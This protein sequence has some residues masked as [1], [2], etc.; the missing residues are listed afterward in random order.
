MVNRIRALAACS[1]PR[2]PSDR[3]HRGPDPAPPAERSIGLLLPDHRRKRLHEYLDVE[4]QAPIVD[5][6]DVE[7]NALLHHVDRGRLSSQPMDLGPT[8]NA[9]LDVMA[10]GIFPDQL[11]VFVVVDRG[12]R[13]WTDQ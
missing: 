12:V 4:P 3:P 2:D 8:G 7:L 13:P 1:Q 11:F 5:V 10:E 9:R 6:P